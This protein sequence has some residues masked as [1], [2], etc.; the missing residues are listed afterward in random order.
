MLALLVW[1]IAEEAMTEEE[2]SCLMQ[3]AQAINEEM[4]VQ[5]PHRGVDVGPWDVS[6]TG[7]RDLD[8]LDSAG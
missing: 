1:I 3:S 5:P 6:E 2:F 8:L 7:W 4:L